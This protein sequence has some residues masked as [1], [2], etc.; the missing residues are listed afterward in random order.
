MARK[1]KCTV[2]GWL[3]VVLLCNV[4]RVD[5]YGGTA[6]EQYLEKIK[7]TAEEQ[8]VDCQNDIAYQK[9][10]QAIDWLALAHQGFKEYG[11]IYNIKIKK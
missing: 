4:L 6:L 7:S 8:H 5:A 10:C 1:N 3:F 11:R 9:L 2:Y